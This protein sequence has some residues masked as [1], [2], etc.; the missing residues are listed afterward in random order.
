MV[1]AIFNYGICH[2]YTYDLPHLN[3][4]SPSWPS[5]GYHIYEHMVDHHQSALWMTI[6]PLTGLFDLTSRDLLVPSGFTHQNKVAKISSDGDRER[7]L[8]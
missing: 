7:K 4:K 1:Y 6:N 8:I 2:N 3:I 5:S